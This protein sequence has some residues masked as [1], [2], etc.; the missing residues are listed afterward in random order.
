[1]PRRAY[2]GH[3]FE[4]Y[5]W[6]LLFP[7][8]LLF[9]EVLVLLRV[10]DLGNPV[11]FG[12]APGSVEAYVSLAGVSVGLLAACVV[13]R[14]LARWRGTHVELFSN[15]I[16]VKEWYGRTRLIPLEGRTEVCAATRIRLPGGFSFELPLAAYGICVLRIGDEEVHLSLGGPSDVHQAIADLTR[17]LDERAR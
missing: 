8:T 5:L 14:S 11:G 15:R 2:S 12:F 6:V 17:F 7:G 1:M 10:L 9:I 4:A 3:R 16:S 13:S